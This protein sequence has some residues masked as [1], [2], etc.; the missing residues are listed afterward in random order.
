ME[1]ATL[2][3]AATRPEN[4]AWGVIGIELTSEAW[5]NEAAVILRDGLRAGRGRSVTPSCKTVGRALVFRGRYTDEGCRAFGLQA[6]AGIDVRRPRSGV[7]VGA[8]SRDSPQCR[9]HWS[10]SPMLALAMAWQSRHAGGV[11]WVGLFRQPRTAWAT[12]NS[13]EYGFYSTGS[14]AVP[15]A[16]WRTGV[17]NAGLPNCARLH[18]PGCPTAVATSSVLC[19]QGWSPGHTKRL[20]VAQ[21]KLFASGP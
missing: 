7:I 21:F 15:H 6:D 13:R 17:A 3:S 1:S 10:A 19:M 14:P 11:W 5:R 2:A 16:R 20:A 4:L 18:A 12:A 8:E 9:S